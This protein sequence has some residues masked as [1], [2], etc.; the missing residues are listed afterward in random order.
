MWHWDQGR[1]D[2]FLFDN[3]L[4]LARLVLKYDF[5]SID[6]ETAKKETGLPFKAPKTHSVWR[7]Y[8]RILK[9]CLLIYE[10]DGEAKPT[11]VAQALG[12]TGQITCDEYLHFF[13]RTFTDP[14]LGLQ[15][16][17]P[18]EP[19]YPLLFSLKYLLT[20]AAI[21]DTSPSSLNEILTAYK[22]TT[23]IGDEEDASFIKLALSN[24][25]KKP[26]K[27]KGQRQPRESL[28]VI[29]Q[30]S[31]LHFDKN[32]IS[33][34]LE[35]DDAKKMFEQLHPISHVGN[36]VEEKI[37][38]T[39]KLFLEDASSDFDYQNSTL[40]RSV[41]SGFLEGSKIKKTHIITERNR[42]LRKAF[43]RKNK[44]VICDICHLNTIKTYP[45]TQG[46]LE[47]HHMMP[48]ASGTRTTQKE[49]ILEDLVALCP[50]CHR[51]VHRYYDMWLR[52]KEHRDFK[53]IDESQ[54]VYQEAKDRFPGALY[55]PK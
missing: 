31:Y 1:L 9:L 2:Y 27:E 51:A 34:S 12:N 38:K 52:K 8:S 4:Q 14:P 33:V 44:P 47:L 39:A 25:A 17:R 54:Q 55:E 43:F 7:N 15:G 5:K 18:N 46:V 40:N 41:E 20:K 21:G 49:T 16:S 23:F 13:I 11:S 53:S 36:D 48:L 19:R 28:K 24:K 3:T 22:T 29:S 30:I 42:M 6:K 32:G 26:I 45:W 10:R 50:N 37:Y 35:K